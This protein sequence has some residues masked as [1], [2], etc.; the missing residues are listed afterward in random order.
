MEVFRHIGNKRDAATEEGDQP[1]VRPFSSCEILNGWIVILTGK[2]KNVYKQIA[3]DPKVEICALKPSGGEWGRI[4]A[5]LVP[6]EDQATK[7]T[8]DF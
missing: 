4:S 7:E 1:R 6:V 5:T 3:N 8:F 2:V